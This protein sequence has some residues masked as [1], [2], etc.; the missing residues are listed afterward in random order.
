SKK[1]SLCDWKGIIHHGLLP[2]SQTINSTIYYEQPDRLKQAIHLKRPELTI[3]KGVVFHQ[4][5]T[6]PHTSLMTRQDLQKL[7]WEVLLHPL[8][9]LDI[10]PSDYYPFLSMENALGSV[11]LNSKE[12]CE[13]W[14]PGFF[15]NKKGSFYEGDIM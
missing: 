13:K 6:R 1:V 5:N 2:Y 8:Y 14:L 11:K 3:K 4:D 15:A 12:V 10:G 7:G 9:S